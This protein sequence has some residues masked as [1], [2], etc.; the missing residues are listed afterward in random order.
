MS[1]SLD[2][3][4]AVIA[5]GVALGVFALLGAGTFLVIRD[6]ARGQGCWGLHIQPTLCPRCDQPA[7]V[8]RLPGNW[9]QA[10]WGGNTCRRCG[11]AYDEWGKPIDWG[12]GVDRERFR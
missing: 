3:I 1:S 12:E 9:R 4:L 8:I 5:V 6:T 7:P 11:C 2:A 10:L